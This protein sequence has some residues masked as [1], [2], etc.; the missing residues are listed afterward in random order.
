M[1]TTLTVDNW[2]LTEL[3]LDS[4]DQSI[5]D[6]YIANAND[7]QGRG[8]DLYVTIDG[9]AA[10]MTG[11]TCYLMWSHENGNQDMTKF[12]ATYS[13]GGHFKVYF[14]NAMMYG[15]EVLA[16]IA[17]F[18]SSDGTKVTGS[19]DFRIHVERNPIDEDAAMSSESM[20][21]FKE[22]VKTLNTLEASVKSAEAKRVSAESTRQSNENTRKANESTRQS[23]E[24]TRQT[25]TAA[26]VA[27]ANTAAANANAS[28]IKDVDVTTGEPGTE[29]SASFADNT[30]SLTIPRGDK[31]EAAN[32]NSVAPLLVS[33]D[34]SVGGPDSVAIGS[35]AYAVSGE[36]VAIGTGSRVD[37]ESSVAIGSGSYVGPED[38]NVVSVG[39][40]EATRRIVNVSSPQQDNDAV[41]YS[42]LVDYVEAQLGAI[43]NASY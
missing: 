8:I 25:D 18:L 42:F 4:A 9:E 21:E 20:S 43:E 33:T 23:N 36:N 15:G 22:A 35:S 28:V 29:A 32:L 6:I 12:T 1:A 24:T 16:R 41:N 2:A 13:A 10:N 19:R 34:A 40:T 3:T 39:N 14:P 27:A 30:L 11:Y 31:G 7:V 17:V 26:A 5:P 38:E 37:G